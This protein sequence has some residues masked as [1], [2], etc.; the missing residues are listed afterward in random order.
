MLNDLTLMEQYASKNNHRLSIK[1]PAR[2]CRQW[3]ILMVITIPQ[4]WEKRPNL[5]LFSV[6]ASQ[7]TGLE[8]T[9]KEQVL[10]VVRMWH[11]SGWVPMPR[12]SPPF[13]TLDP[14]MS[15]KSYPQ[16]SSKKFKTWGKSN[17]TR[18]HVRARTHTNTQYLHLKFLFCEMAWK[19]AYSFP[20]GSGASHYHCS[21][22]PVGLSFNKHIS[23]SN[24]KGRK[25]KVHDKKHNT[26][27]T[28]K[29]F[30]QKCLSA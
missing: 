3:K 24:Y 12:M 5:L 13:Q 27:E 25:M 4:N 21:L 17:Y 22:P 20:V 23:S 26:L 16:D 2:V 10:E 14:F 19:L 15:P 29:C 28:F 18:T 1:M 7:N 8:Y 30:L 6:C 9:L 11:F